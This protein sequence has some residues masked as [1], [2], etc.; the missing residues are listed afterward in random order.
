MDD[1]VCTPV[2]HVLVNVKDPRCQCGMY[3]T[4]VHVIDGVL[5]AED[6]YILEDT[7]KTRLGDTSIFP[8]KEKDNE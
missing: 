5:D 2:M 4:W 3:E 1:L 6:F 7:G 8:I